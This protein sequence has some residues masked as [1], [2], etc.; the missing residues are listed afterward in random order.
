MVFKGEL[1]SNNNF[2]SVP[3]ARFFFGFVCLFASPSK[4]KL[5]P[6]SVSCKA[7]LGFLFLDAGAAERHSDVLSA[8]VVG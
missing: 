6:P 2:V 4:A 8:Q 1:E 5:G 3:S 7:N